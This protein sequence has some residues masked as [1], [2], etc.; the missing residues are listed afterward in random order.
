MYS[1]NNM[2]W[3]VIRSYYSI[4]IFFNYGYSVV[5][6]DESRKIYRLSDN[7]RAWIEIGEI[8]ERRDSFG[9]A[10]LNG[11]IYITGGDGSLTLY[12]K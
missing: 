11:R 1:N 4:F 5:D 7:E 12:Y 3:T 2:R 10:L 6:G 9:V 8:P